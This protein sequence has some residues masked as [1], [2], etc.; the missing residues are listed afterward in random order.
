MIDLPSHATASDGELSPSALVDQAV[1]TGLSALAL[2]DHDTVSGVAE[3]RTRAAER[4]L[5]LVAGVELEIAF[6]PGEFHLLGLGV[7]ENDL[8]L[9]GAL[10][11]LADARRD[12]NRNIVELMRS[13]GIDADY[14]EIVRSAGTPHLGRPHLADHLVRARAART[15]QDAFDRFLGKGRPFYL[16]KECLEF[17]DALRLIR[18]SGGIAVVAHPYSLFVSKT[19]LAGLMDEWKERGIEGIEAHHPTAKLGQCRILERMALERGFAV[20]AGSDWHGPGRPECGL[21]RS[22]GGI[23]VPDALLETLDLRLGRRL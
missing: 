18:G 1:K 4:G 20:T 13:A 11:L 17:G 7:D 19:K 14:E 5:R 6:E 16:P 8:A 9:R 22:A 21:G 2:T 12:R 3:A 15:R 23:Q 10:S